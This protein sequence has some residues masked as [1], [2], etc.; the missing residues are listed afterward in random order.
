MTGV[1]V[2]EYDPMDADQNS[3]NN[4]A[5][6]ARETIVI[7]EDDASSSN[8]QSSSIR[9]LWLTMTMTRGMQAY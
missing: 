3:F 7:Y 2:A 1:A 9:S 6:L 8:P 5:L 4:A